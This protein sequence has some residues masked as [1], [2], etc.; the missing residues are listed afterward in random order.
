[1]A[2]PAGRHGG[3]RVAALAA[4][5]A[6]LLAIALSA[7][8]CGTYV[9]IRTGREKFAILSRLDDTGTL[10]ASVVARRQAMLSGLA[11]FIAAEENLDEIARAFPL[12]AAGLKNDDPAIRAIQIFPPSG[13]VLVYPLAGNEA[14]A[15]RTLEDLL[16]DERPDVR[17]DVRRTVLSGRIALSAPYVLRQGGQGLVARQA[18]GRDGRLWGIITVVLDMGPLLASAGISEGGVPEGLAILDGDGKPF[19]GRE[20][21]A[22][23]DPITSKVNLPDGHWTLTQSFP[24]A[25]REAIDRE[26]LLFAM[27]GC[28]VSLALA[29]LAYLGA[30]RLQ[31]MRR[32]LAEG[33]KERGQSDEAL[34]SSEEK[35]RLLFDTIADSVIIYEPEGRIVLTNKSVAANLGYPPDRE[36]PIKDIAETV[37]PDQ[38]P[39]VPERIRK[40]CEL[41]E[42]VFESAHLRSDGSSFPVETRSRVI[43]F[44]GRT[45]IMS[46]SR[47][48]GERKRAEQEI[49]RVN[50]SLETRVAERTL[51]LQIANR[52]LEAFG[53]SI[54][55]DLRAPLRAIKGFS[56][57]LQEQHSQGLNDEGKRLLE[58]VRKNAF[59]M[60]RL[61]TDLMDL[62][63]ITRD[64]PRAVRV[65]MATLAGIVWSE[66]ADPETLAS[67]TLDLRQLP[68]ACGDPSLLRQVWTNLLSNAI[69]Y[70][71]KSPVRRVEIGS[72]SEPGS[73][74]YYVRD[75]GAG[76]DPEYA[77]KMF[78]VFQRLHKDD[79]FEGSG[80]GL[81]IVQ[82]IVARHGG[83]IWAEGEPGRGAAFFFTI[84]ER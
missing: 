5:A 53:Y 27:A 41:G 11:A 79:E 58:T 51:Q 45:A 2:A 62:S 9:R 12:Y 67:F 15:G 61:I 78:G 65:D 16:G 35:F 71:L 17:E 18:V 36:L 60:D 26:K 64:E 73:S 43:D 76:F 83:R 46:V 54:S 81:A 7:Q 24:R 25:E 70:S 28:A 10:L 80:V 42:L 50:A 1:M 57:Y 74:A 49:L 29:F 44:M 84:P 68:P 30:R 72:F 48:I 6:F 38:S 23:D 52:E 55:H 59:R 33:E 47:D 3:R 19:Y 82:R 22:G 34:R 21:A 31:S 69:K 13:K 37:A 39:F 56:C 40:I 32:A 4:A 63:Q 66:S 75:W 77:G 20:I 14:V 8:L